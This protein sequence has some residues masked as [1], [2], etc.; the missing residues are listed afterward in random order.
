MVRHVVSHLDIWL[1][2]RSKGWLSITGLLGFPVLILTTKGART[3]ILRETPLI[4]VKSSENVAVIASSL[5]STNHP[6]WYRNLLADPEASLSFEGR[7]GFYTSRQLEG[8]ERQEYWQRMLEIYPGYNRY[9]EL[10]VG[11]HIPVIL[12]F[13]LDRKFFPLNL[14]SE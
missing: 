13:P 14:S 3:G 9:A 10:A 2:H 8:T 12:F 11:R 5:G 1:F 6:Q 7:Q 4:Y